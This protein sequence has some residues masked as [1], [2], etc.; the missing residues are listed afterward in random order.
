[1]LNNPSFKV[2]RIEEPFVFKDAEELKHF[3]DG[4]CP[5]AWSM[6]ADLGSGTGLK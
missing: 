1:M 3:I 6:P 2:A 5:L 4:L